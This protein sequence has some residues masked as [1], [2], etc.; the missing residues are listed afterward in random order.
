MFRMHRQTDRQTHRHTDR[1]LH[2]N[3]FGHV[4][5]V[6][7]GLTLIQPIKNVQTYTVIALLE[8]PM[9]GLL[10]IICDKFHSFGA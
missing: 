2:I 1:L 7:R 6:A 3:F 5:V 8:L 10:Q 9:V 4:E